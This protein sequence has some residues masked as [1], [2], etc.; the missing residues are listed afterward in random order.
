MLAP[1]AVLSIYNPLIG[2]AISPGE[3]L[4]I[5]GSNLSTAPVTSSNIPLTTT[6]GGTSVSIGGIPA[7][8][9]Y[10]SPT[11]INAQAPFELVPGNQYQVVINS[12]GALA[13]PGTIRSCLRN[14][15]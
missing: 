3:I 4:Q 13:A 6:L 7:P 9:Y 8:L 12:N 1:D 10:V 15:A 5:Y 2:G 14:P 11:Q